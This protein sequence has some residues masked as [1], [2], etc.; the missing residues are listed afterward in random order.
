MSVFEF[1]FLASTTSMTMFPFGSIIIGFIISDLIS[2]LPPTSLIFP[3]LH[4]WSSKSLNFSW[5]CNQFFDGLCLVKTECG[6]IFR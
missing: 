6:N 1:R 3:D 2:V 5:Q 4:G